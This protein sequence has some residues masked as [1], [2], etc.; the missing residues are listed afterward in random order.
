MK[1]SN[2]LQY[3]PEFHKYCRTKITRI[4]RNL[5]ESNESSVLHSFVFKKKEEN[6]RLEQVKCI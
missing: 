3:F 4:R 6:L 5:L 2:N 1:F